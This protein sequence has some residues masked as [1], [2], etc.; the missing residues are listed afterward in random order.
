MW[1]SLDRERAGVA[2]LLGSL[3]EAQWATPSLCRGWTVRDVAAHLTLGPQTTV[4]G[5]VVEIVRAR[6]SFNRMV[7]RTARRHATHPLDQLIAELLGVVGSR[8]LAPG[9][10]LV[11]ALMDVL[12]HGQDIAVPLGLRHPM[13]P[14]AAQASAEHLWRTGFPF[15]ARRR[16]GG[17]H[18]TATDTDWTA[19]D[20][21]EVR[22]PV[23]AILPLLAGR[24]A[25][26][27]MLAGDGIPALATRLSTRVPQRAPTAPDHHHHHH[28]EAGEPTRPRDTPRRARALL[29][30]PST[31]STP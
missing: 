14:E 23:A 26:L 4:R 31:A 13:P 8:R 16:L 5:A 12:V 1:Q 9:Q 11:D 6:G 28:V 18:L 19:G 20:G 17:F 7:D 22:G 30:T 29:W 25:T 15:H 2:D 24:S 21:A 10:K 3:T 27:P